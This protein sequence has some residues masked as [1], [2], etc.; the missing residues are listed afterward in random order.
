MEPLL[1]QDQVARRGGD[2]GSNIARVF[3]HLARN[4]ERPAVPYDH[5]LRQAVLG[6]RLCADQLLGGDDECGIDDC[7]AVVFADQSKA[8]E[9]LPMPGSRRSSGGGNALAGCFAGF[10]TKWCAAR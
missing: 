6:C 4:V 7:P 3:A 2:M 1:T 10:L 5:V 9:R 8:F